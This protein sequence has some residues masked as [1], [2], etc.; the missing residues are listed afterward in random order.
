MGGSCQVFR[1]AFIILI[2]VP[3][4][5]KILHHLV[6][7]SDY[8]EIFKVKTLGFIYKQALEQ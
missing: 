4:E 8:V 7:G 1:D 6:S 5:L 2:F 3:Y